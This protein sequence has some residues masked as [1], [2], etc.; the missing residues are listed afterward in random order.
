MDL[1]RASILLKKINYLHDSMQSDA[2]RIADIERDLMRQYVRDLY[3]CY[4]TADTPD[5]PTPRP[6]ERSNRSLESN[7]LNK[8]PPRPIQRQPEPAPQVSL[9]DPMPEAPAPKAEVEVAA[10][11]S[12]PTPPPSRPEPKPTPAVTP[13]PPQPQPP[14]PEK[15]PR[16]EPTVPEPTPEPE[17]KPHPILPKERAPRRDPAVEALF[18]Q[19]PSLNDLSSRLSNSRIDNLQRAFSINDRI[20]AINELFK[21]RQQA[22][23]EAVNQLNG[24]RNFGE[25]ETYLKQHV[26]PEQQ[27]TDPRREEA[28]RHFI[29]LVRRRYA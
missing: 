9:P 25:A 23:E 2:D 4:T 3:E 27:W 16:P 18:E 24:F 29:K 22:L 10:A 6:T 8:V 26:I 15:L 7:R 1:D 28:A 21:G 14:I 20:L 13:K 12:Q 19:A 11:P 17:P 5:R